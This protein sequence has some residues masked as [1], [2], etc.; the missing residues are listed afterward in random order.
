LGSTVERVVL[1]TQG[2]I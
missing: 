1:I 2:V